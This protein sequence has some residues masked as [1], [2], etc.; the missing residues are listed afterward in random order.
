MSV[1]LCVLVFVLGDICTA[2]IYKFYYLTYVELRWLYLALLYYIIYIHLKYQTNIFL[3]SGLYE[4]VGQLLSGAQVLARQLG[5][6]DCSSNPFNKPL[7]SIE[8]I[9]LSS[10][11]LLIVVLFV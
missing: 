1:C 4:S 7:H 5:L 10:D 6:S 9:N 11:L 8:L 2:R 3:S